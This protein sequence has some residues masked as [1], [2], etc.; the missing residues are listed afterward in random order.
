MDLAENMT[1]EGISISSSLKRKWNEVEADNRES[2]MGQPEYEYSRKK[3]KKK[4]K[5]VDDLSYCKKMIEH[6]N[7]SSDEDK[8]KRKKSKKSRFK[9]IDSDRLASQVSG[10]VVDALSNMFEKQKKKKKS[11]E[12]IRK[13]ALENSIHCI[14]KE[15]EPRDETGVVDSVNSGVVEIHAP[16]EESHLPCEKQK[17]RKKKK[18][19]K[20]KVRETDLDNSVY[21][22]VEAGDE[23]GIVASAKEIQGD[24]ERGLVEVD[25]PLKELSVSS[26]SNSSNSSRRKRKFKLATTSDLN[27]LKSNPEEEVSSNYTLSSSIVSEP[28]DEPMNEFILPDPCV[29]SMAVYS[30]SNLPLSCSSSQE[31][32]G[33]DPNISDVIEQEQEQIEDVAMTSGSWHVPVTPKNKSQI[34]NIARAAVNEV[35]T[36][37]SGH[38]SLLGDSSGMKS[39]N[40]RTLSHYELLCKTTPTDL[41]TVVNED[42]KAVE[43]FEEKENSNSRSPPGPEM[44]SK[45]STE[46]SDPPMKK[47]VTIKDLYRTP[48]RKKVPTVLYEACKFIFSQNVEVSAL[49]IAYTGHCVPGDRDYRR[50]L[51]REY[52]AKFGRYHDEQDS[53]LLERFDTLVQHGVVEDKEEFCNFLNIYCNGKDQ[54][55][56]MKNRRSIGVRNIVGLYVGQDMPNKIAAVHCL[57]L[58]RLVLGTSY[59]FPRPETVIS[60]DDNNSQV[61]QAEDDVPED[62]GDNSVANRDVEPVKR[63]VRKWTKD[64]DMFLIQ[65]VTERGATRVENIDYMMVDWEGIAESLDRK[66]NCVAEHWSRVVQPILVEDTDPALVISYRRKLLEEVIKMEAG[67]RKEIDW[68]SLSKKFHPRS[69]YAIQMNFHDLVRGGRASS[70]TDSAQEFK[71][72]V[73]NALAKVNWISSLPEKKMGKYFKRT[74]Y[75]EELREYYWDLLN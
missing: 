49:N 2:G 68:K 10:L 30:N 20:D 66:T 40:R 11:K 60:T 55:E 73:T 39:R 19:S 14:E 34:K 38:D 58:I 67:H 29:S 42:S 36:D 31:M 57:R 15:I 18:R 59:L 61:E 54:K 33:V 7:G 62:V 5:K 32:N 52:K 6:D 45:M 26:S 23:T 28:I 3:K 69:T 46:D 72:R 53:M 24:M 50:L 47:I 70:T 75:K 43:Y 56:L 4:S 41:H 48:K 51:R 65:E 12:K 71:D 1:G 74:S 13:A 16:L 44:D 21:C 8:K 9:T 22:A 17:K 63:I 64:E 35:M 25:A 37:T 27:L